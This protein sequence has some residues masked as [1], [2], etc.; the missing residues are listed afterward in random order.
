MAQYP[1]KLLKDTNSNPF[2]PFVTTD[3][4]LKNNS[5][6]NLQQILDDMYTKAQV[7]Q[8]ITNLGTILS[9]RGVVDTTSQL[10]SSGMTAGWVYVVRNYPQAQGGTTHAVIWDGT[11][12]EDL[13]ESVN[14]DLYYSKT[15]VDSNIA[16]AISISNATERTTT[17]TAIASSL[18]TA[19]NYTDQVE[20]KLNT[21]KDKDLTDEAHGMRINENNKFEYWDG[22][23]W[24]E[25][26]G[27]GGG[28]GDVIGPSSSV[29][30]TLAVF[31]GTSGKLIKNIPSIKYHDDVAEDYLN[32]GGVSIG[33]INW[34]AHP[35]FPYLYKTVANLDKPNRP[36]HAATKEYVDDILSGYQIQKNGTDGVGIINFKTEDDGDI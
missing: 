10:P 3:A 25:V 30:K 28:G 31:D 21:H 29:D 27:G 15:E 19:K 23:E 17:N 4:V 33:Y 34:S 7:D 16:T 1:V 32:I 20:T 18:T 2:F 36:K 5:S 13:G 26:S 8:K 35:E 9:F 24:V 6:L 11:K 14:L 12:W 22:T